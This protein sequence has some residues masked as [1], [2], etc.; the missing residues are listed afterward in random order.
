[1]NDVVITKSGEETLA[2]GREFSA[3]LQPMDVVFLI[4][5]LGAGKTT[6]TKGIAEGLGIESRV[7]SPTFV[8]LR[9]HSFNSPTTNHQS[10]DILT[11]YHLDLYRLDSEKH[12]KEV[13]IDDIL[14][15][16]NGVT[17][18][19][20]PEVAQGLVE[21]KVWKIIFEHVKDDRKITF[22]YE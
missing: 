7:I 15:D 1:M 12:A 3:K 21:G 9:T 13:G 18:I 14:Q 17:V 22:K 8:V 5:E 2:L 4:G 19:E 11:L 16:K 10:Q 20:W 6:F